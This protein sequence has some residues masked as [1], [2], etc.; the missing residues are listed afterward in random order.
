MSSNQQRDF[1]THLF[2]PDSFYTENRG[3]SEYDSN[4]AATAR[5]PTAPSSPHQ[6]IFLENMDA[7][8]HDL[9]MVHDVLGDT[10]YSEDTSSDMSISTDSGSAMEDF[11][12]HSVDMTQYDSALSSQDDESV[13]TLD[14]MDTISK[15]DLLLNK[16]KETVDK[17]NAPLRRILQL[18]T[19][20]ETSCLEYHNDIIGTLN[21]QNRYDHSIATEFFLAGK[22]TFLA[23]QE[24]FS[25]QDKTSK[26][27]KNCRRI[28]VESARLR[29]WETQYQVIIYDSWKWGGN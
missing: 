8:L 19:H 15:L 16:S 29:C 18:A 21:I 6:E 11:N 22:F 10:V 7:V 23:L 20:R 3:V 13:D 26:T 12:T 4:S 27:W 2:T 1:Y 9:D 17:R 25:S 28:E 24:P 5:D 14:S